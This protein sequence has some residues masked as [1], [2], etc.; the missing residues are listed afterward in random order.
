MNISKITYSVEATIPHPEIGYANMKPHISAEI[1][2]NEGDDPATA[3]DQLKEFV[4]S[5][6]IESAQWCWG[7]MKKEK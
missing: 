3:K 4:Q 7:R 2:L 1:T 6:Y 5:F